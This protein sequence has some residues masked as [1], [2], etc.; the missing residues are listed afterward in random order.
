LVEHN[1]DPRPFARVVDADSILD[2][3]ER[4]CERT[5]DSGH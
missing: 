4:V 1:K 5:S 3:V 2:R